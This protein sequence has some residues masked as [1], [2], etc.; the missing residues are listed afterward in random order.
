MAQS[1]VE[2]DELLRYRLPLFFLIL[3]AS[4]C[5]DLLQI[6]ADEAQ[7]LDAMSLSG[8]IQFVCDL[9]VRQLKVEMSQLNV[10]SQFR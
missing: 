1:T 8:R 4:A 2:G 10:D 6:S 7:R 5:D 3:Y 9:L